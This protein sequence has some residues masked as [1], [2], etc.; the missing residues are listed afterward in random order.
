MK[1]PLLFTR[2]DREARESHQIWAS[3]Y[4]DAHLEAIKAGLP[5]SEAAD[6]GTRAAEAA[7]KA[8]GLDTAAPKA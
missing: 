5:E 3:A 7:C 8:A 2:S 4:S 6:A 1:H